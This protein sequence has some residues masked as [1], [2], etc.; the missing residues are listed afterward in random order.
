MAMLTLNLHACQE[1]LT[2]SYLIN[3]SS[4]TCFMFLVIVLQ[5]LSQTL[6]KV[7]EHLWL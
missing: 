3:Q 4:Y 6:I 7:T 1:N 2:D 5:T